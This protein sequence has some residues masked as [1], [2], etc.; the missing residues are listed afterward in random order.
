MG[1]NR[2]PISSDFLWKMDLP[3]LSISKSRKHQGAE[4]Q[5]KRSFESKHLIPNPIQF[6]K[7][8]RFYLLMEGHFCEKNNL[9]NDECYFFTLPRISKI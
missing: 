6:Q 4:V 8:S 1:L 3:G 2:I 7:I 9:V 5:K